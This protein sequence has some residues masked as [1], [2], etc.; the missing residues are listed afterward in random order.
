MATINTSSILSKLQKWSKSDEGKKTM[1]H[2][3]HDLEVNGVST[4][5]AGSLIM[6]PQMK[7]LAA[8]ALIWQVNEIVDNYRAAGKIPDSIAAL[9]ST[10]G[11]G[12]I[13]YME[14]STYFGSKISLSFQDDVYRNSLW[15]EDK[16]T[17]EQLRTG[18]GIDNIVMLFNDGYGPI[19]QVWGRWETHND[20]LVGSKTFREHLGF[21]DEAVEI[22][23]ATDGLH[24][25]CYAYIWRG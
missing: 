23:N 1:D 16:E 14:N 25:N 13:E 18:D 11:Y 24:Y 7:Y 12:S 20:I 21:L 22:F 6:T 15:Y 9:A 5:N 19:K 2:A 8:R 17:G 4:T 10:L 3:I